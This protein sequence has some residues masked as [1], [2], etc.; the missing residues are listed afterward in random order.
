MFIVFA[1]KNYA[2]YHLGEPL[3]PPRT[4]YICKNV[5]DMYVNLYMLCAFCV[6]LLGCY[7]R[8]ASHDVDDVSIVSVVRNYPR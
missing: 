2:R 1:Y 7:P 6:F 8:E 3:R 4:L 5:Y